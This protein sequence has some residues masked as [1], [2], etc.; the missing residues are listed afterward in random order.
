MCRLS[1][2]GLGLGAQSR[3]VRLRALTCWSATTG[4]SL[5]LSRSTPILY[6]LQRR[7]SSSSLAGRL[8]GLTSLYGSSECPL[9]VCSQIEVRARVSSRTE[10]EGEGRAGVS[11]QA[12]GSG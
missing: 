11:G 7:R 9:W 6:S 3:R 5:T 4:A 10:A 2:P 8:S 1:P 12:S